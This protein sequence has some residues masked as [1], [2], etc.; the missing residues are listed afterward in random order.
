MRNLFKKAG[1]LS[2]LSSIL[3]LILGILLI[4]NPEQIVQAISYIIGGILIIMGIF[5]IISY[6]T[7]KDAY[8]FYDF[9]L[10]Y[11]SLCAIL[12]IIV[13]V[14][15]KSI[16]SFFGIIIGI[17]IIL[18]GISRINLSFKIKDAGVNYWFVSLLISILILVAGI[19][20]IFVPGTIL[21]T[22]GF[23]LIIYSIMDIIGNIIYMVNM[24]KFFK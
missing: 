23:I 19:Y 11:G 24:N 13:M 17:W 5:R 14:C 6:F 7:S 10:I 2:F 12:G 16:A 1:Y 9:N 18:S 22:L 8:V 4:N 20:I 21:V 15:G 3:F